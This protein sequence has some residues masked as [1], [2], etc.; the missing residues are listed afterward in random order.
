MRRALAIITSFL[1]FVAVYTIVLGDRS[2]QGNEIVV[3]PASTIQLRDSVI[4]LRGGGGPLFGEYAVNGYSSHT[5]SAFLFADPLFGR[6]ERAELTERTGLRNLILGSRSRGA[7]GDD[8][9]IGELE[10]LFR[11]VRSLCEKHPSP[12]P[13]PVCEDLRDYTGF[14]TYL[15]EILGDGDEIAWGSV[16]E[17][18]RRLRFAREILEQP[19]T[20][21][22]EPSPPSSSTLKPN[23]LFDNRLGGT[24]V[25]PHQFTDESAI[26]RPVSDVARPE[27]GAGI[28]SYAQLPR[29]RASYTAPPETARVGQKYLIRLRINRGTPTH[30]TTASAHDPIAA[31]PAARMAA[32]DTLTVSVDV[33]VGLEMAAMLAGENFR[34]VQKTPSLTHGIPQAVLQDRDAVW[35]W[36]VTPRASGEQPLSLRIHT[37]LTSGDQKSPPI[38]EV[39]FEKKILVDFDLVGTADIFWEEHP[40]ESLTI[41]GLILTVAGLVVAWRQLRQG[42]SERPEPEADPAAAG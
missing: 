12:P 28:N 8:G 29:G 25:P 34:V 2:D 27:V 13:T 18:V 23:P 4:A 36:E 7:P 17:E 21:V 16:Y 11:A 3:G 24:V 40:A 30:H 35:E 15:D 42:K 1:G 5:M 14:R 22:S 38:E 37:I 10:Y 26:S 9:L 41:V 6:I 33:P 39:V 31:L 32:V 20:R 19:H